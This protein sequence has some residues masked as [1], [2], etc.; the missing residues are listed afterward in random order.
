MR[1]H[2][3]FSIVMLVIQLAFIGLF[4]VT[5]S[6]TVG[7]LRHAKRA[8][9]TIIG[10][11]EYS[12]SDGTT[13]APIIRFNAANDQTYEFERGYSSGWVDYKVEDY[14][15]VLYTT[16]PVFRA[17]IAGFWGTWLWSVITGALAL[18]T[19][20]PNG[21]WLVGRLGRSRS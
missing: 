9:G 2:R 17:R 11:A 4:A 21:L 16:D 12:D 6:Q 1:Y 13:Y 3:R 20:I 8:T 18:L 19:G 7:F 5:T 14:I 10:I 15:D